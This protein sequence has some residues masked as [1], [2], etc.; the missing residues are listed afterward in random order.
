MY[1]NDLPGTERFRKSAQ[2]GGIGV[3]AGM[4]IYVVHMPF[5]YP[6]FQDGHVFFVPITAPE[7]VKKKCIFGGLAQ[8]F[9]QFLDHGVAHKNEIIVAHV[10]KTFV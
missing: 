3:P 2:C 9:G 1:G 10:V 6:V 5:G 8:L 7:A 4:C